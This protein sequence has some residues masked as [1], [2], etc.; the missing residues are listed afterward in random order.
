[1]GNI[2]KM[3]RLSAC[4]MF[5]CFESLC[6]CPS[7]LRGFVVVDLYVLALR[8]REFAKTLGAVYFVVVAY[9]LEGSVKTLGAV[10]F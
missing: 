1:M 6:S 4:C 10:Y 7:A 3:H 5:A 2:Q 9:G 8:T